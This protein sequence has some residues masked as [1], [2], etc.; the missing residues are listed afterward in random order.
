MAIF[1]AIEVGGT[2]VV[3]GIGNAA[4]GSLET[5]RID[6]VDPAGT[7]GAIE[8]FFLGATRRHGPIAALGIGSFGPLDLERDSASYGRIIA[9]PKPGWQG[10]DLPAALRR[11]LG[12]PV[13]IS[14]DVNAAA[15]AEARLGA[16]R[17]R[18]SVAYVTIGTGIGVGLIVGDSM[19]HGAGHPEAGHI[20][21]RRHAAHAGFAGICPFHGDCLEGLAAGPAIVA[22][23]GASLAGL[24]GDHPAWDAQADYIGQLCAT[25]I[26]TVTPEHIVLG[27]GVMAQQRLLPAVRQETLRRLAGYCAAWDSLEVAEAR[28]TSPGCAE[29]PGLVGAYILAERIAP[30]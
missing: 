27:G 17:G 15:L 4:N 23:W 16:A 22:A 10:A 19:V 5:T 26:L 30:D 7:I 18:K 28:I 11:A 14:T 21:P 12:V 3:C 24:A 2:K 9:T 6:T 25:L 1:G 20:L 29:P 8:A 13:A